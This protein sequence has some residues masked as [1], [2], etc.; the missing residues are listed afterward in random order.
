MAVNGMQQ[1]APAKTG[2]SDRQLAS[3]R[4]ASFGAL[5]MLIVQFAIGIV[6]NLYVTVPS[7]DHGSGFLTA[8]GRALSRGPA[9]LATHAGLGLLI[10]LAASG[11]IVRALLARHAAVLVLAVAGLLAILGA[12]LNGVRFVESG[13]ASASFA[14]ALATAV[15]MLCYA[16]RLFV[17]GSSRAAVT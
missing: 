9:A 6:V 5:V 17:L 12:A 14:M 11:L 8:I 16:I 7:A 4:G 3:L 15:A 1:T 13:A 10:I 2:L